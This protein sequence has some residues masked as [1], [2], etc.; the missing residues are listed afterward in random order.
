MKNFLGLVFSL[1]II[2]AICAAVL[3][4]VSALTEEPIKKMGEERKKSAVKAVM[5]AAVEKIDEAGEVFI[6]RDAS[7]KAVGYAA[8][9]IDAGGYGGDIKLMVGFEADA[10]TVVRYITL[11][12]AETPGLGMKL[13]TP[14][15]SGQFSGKDGSSLKVAKEGGQIEAITA[16][17]ITSS[18][19]CRAIENAHKKAVAAK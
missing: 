19:V 7:G 6:G 5:P 15:F 9:G 16:A 3:A 14:E 8:E 17:T 12:A 10:K 1:T 18:A 4:N 13:S 11:F 2:S